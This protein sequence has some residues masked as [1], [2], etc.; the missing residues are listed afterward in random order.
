MLD[1]FEPQNITVGSPLNPRIPD[2]EQRT[3]YIL[4]TIM[5]IALGAAMVLVVAVP[6]LFGFSAAFRR[7][8]R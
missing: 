2:D 5:I 7:S 6:A 1:E 8:S 4:D 3:D